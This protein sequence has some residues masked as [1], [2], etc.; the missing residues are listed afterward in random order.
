VSAS[1]Q[2]LANGQQ[3]NAAAGNYR[4][5]WEELSRASQAAG[6]SVRAEVMAGLRELASEDQL[7]SDVSLSSGN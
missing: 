7:R 1:L 6:H 5:A 2:V 3:V 4:A